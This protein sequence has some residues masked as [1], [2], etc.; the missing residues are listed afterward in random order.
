VIIRIVLA[1][2]VLVLSGEIIR[3]RNG[4]EGTF[5]LFMLKSRSGI[6]IIDKTSKKNQSAWKFFA[7]W[8][9]TVSF[10]LFA[11]P[12]FRKKMDKRAFALG[13]ISLIIIIL[14]V[15]PATV[16]SISQI[17]IPQIQSSIGPVM[18]CLTQSYNPLNSALNMLYSPFDLLIMAITI[19]GG[20]ALL[21]PFLLLFNA[22]SILYAIGAALYSHGSN[23]SYTYNA[24]NSQL[25]G[26]APLIPG[27]TMPLAAG[28]IT[29]FILLVIHEF[30]HGVLS[31]I[32]KVKLKS[33]GLL[34]FG[35][36]PVG[37]FVEPEEKNIKKLSKAK[38]N[39]ISIAG[40]SANLV[41]TF[42]FFALTILF[43]F[44]VLPYIMSSSII[45]TGT[46][47]GYAAYNVIPVGSTILSVN[48]IS[49][50]NVSQLS[51][52]ENSIIPGS[53]AR[54]QTLNNTYSLKTSSNSKF[55]VYLCNA[56]ILHSSKP[57]APELYF[58]YVIILLSLL[59]NFSVAAVNLLPLP[60]LD[61]WRIY[62]LELGSKSKWIMA[63]E[64][65]L[66]LALLI[67]V[68]PFITSIL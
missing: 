31:R 32:S 39:R 5:G 48:N 21:I 13:I 7:D 46:I 26:V 56:S 47:P 10:G 12:L 23:A 8:G 33:T 54:V 38:Q 64:I 34:I 62:N 18:S 20:L 66:L 15:F 30:S 17:D 9:L 41:A 16:L 63:I 28:L 59:L 68:L 65:I 60:G 50:H 3:K 45:V 25:P 67:N 24:I 2:L 29:L 43:L 14:F 35:I 44:Y 6:N 36:I 55:G 11:Y 57:F 42:V 19:I 4:Y 27:I 1:L 58:I 61:G 22:G 37:A 51:I 49:I 40:V 52:I 53:A